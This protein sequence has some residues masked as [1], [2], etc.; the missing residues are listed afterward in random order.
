MENLRSA[1]LGKINDVK[2]SALAENKKVWTK[3]NI[4][5]IS[6]FTI[7]TGTGIGKGEFGFPTYS[8]S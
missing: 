8:P 1:Q 5:E 6:K 2:F 7:L 4:T 3:P